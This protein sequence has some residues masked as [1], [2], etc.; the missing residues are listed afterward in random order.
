M[1]IGVPTEIK[2]DE[3]RVSLSPAGAAAFRTHAHR[4]IVQSGAGVGSG[5]SDREYREAGALIVRA[6]GEVWGRADMV[7]K[8]K[9]PQ[10]TEFRYLRPGKI[11]FTY[12]H[13]AP[14]KRLAHELVKQH[15]RAPATSTAPMT[16][17][18]WRTSSSMVARLDITVVA[19][20]PRR[21]LK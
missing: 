15:V 7:V 4:V 1:L 18:A 13:L 19:C 11:L 21:S 9:E 5:F 16:R 8:V 12:L 10:R 2:A 6:P 20:P 17:S 3:R 14:D